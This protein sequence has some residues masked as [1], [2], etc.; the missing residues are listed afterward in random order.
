[1]SGFTIIEDD[2]SNG[3]RFKFQMD[4]NYDDIFTISDVGILFKKIF[5]LPGDLV[6]YF[7]TKNH[8][9]ELLKFFEVAHY[10]SYGS[11]F[12][13]IIS[14]IVWLIVLAIFVDGY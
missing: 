3:N 11:I 13:W 7:I 8:E 14:I 5:L 10:P 1:M 2:L 4:A 12:T 6:E 9:M